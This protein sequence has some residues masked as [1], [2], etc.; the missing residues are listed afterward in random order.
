MNKR[1]YALL[2]AT[3]FIAAAC[4]TQTTD[5]GLVFKTANPALS[6]GFR[7]APAPPIPAIEPQLLPTVTPT[8]LPVT[9][10]PDCLIKGNVSSSDEL[11][12]HVPGGASYNATVI[13]ETHVNAA[14]V[15]EQYFCTEQEAIDAGFRKA[16]R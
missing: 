11:I 10:P 1:I 14:G 8:P 2:F 6:I 12:F 5:N 13:D 7:L 4:G 9:A 15:H 16:S 3:L